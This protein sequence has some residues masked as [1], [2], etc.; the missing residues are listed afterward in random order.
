[1]S[2]NRQQGVIV[3]LSLYTHTHTHTYAQQQQPLLNGPQA[4][5]HS[6]AERERAVA[7]GRSQPPVLLFFIRSLL[8]SLSLLYFVCV[9]VLIRGTRIQKGRT[10]P[11]NCGGL[12]SSSSSLLGFETSA[13]PIRKRKKDDQ[14]FFFSFFFLPVWRYRGPGLVHVQK[15]KKTIRWRRLS[16]SLSRLFE[17]NQLGLAPS[18]SVQL[19]SF[20]ISSGATPSLSLYS[21]WFSLWQLLMAWRHS[22]KISRN[23]YLPTTTYLLWLFFYVRL[24]K[25]IINEACSQYRLSLFSRLLFQLSI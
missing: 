5:G 24:F 19:L 15:K 8:G 17:C 22:E 9:C 14:G 6:I 7:A 20:L 3:Y 25:T 16:W 1:M 13:G 11:L 4:D 18:L 12:F 23:I 10:Q 21:T 2:H